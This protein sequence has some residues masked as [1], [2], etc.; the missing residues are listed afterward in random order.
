MRHIA[1]HAV[2]PDRYKEKPPCD[3]CILFLTS[4][5]ES[6]IPIDHLT[7]KQSA[8]SFFC[9][10]AEFALS[11][12]NP[13]LFLFPCVPIL[14][15]WSEIS[16]A[17]PS[18]LDLLR[19]HISPS[20]RFWGF[21]AYH[22]V[23]H[24]KRITAVFSMWADASIMSPPPQNGRHWRQKERMKLTCLTSSTSLLNLMNTHWYLTIHMSLTPTLCITRYFGP[25]N[26]NNIF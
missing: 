15:R 1:Q 24:H 26:L 25:E 10:W 8:F 18:Y 22:S 2:D 19:S 3:T 20:I 13:F 9:G 5:P 11:A 17:F 6:K 21:C 12:R 7:I 14:Q 4:V 16:S 23:A